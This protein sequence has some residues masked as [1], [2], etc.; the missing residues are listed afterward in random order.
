MKYVV[1]ENVGIEDDDGA[2]ACAMHTVI[3]VVFYVFNVAGHGTPHT[4][5]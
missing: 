3:V 5:M 4:E 2:I 1:V